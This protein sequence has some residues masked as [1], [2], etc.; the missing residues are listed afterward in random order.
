[1]GNAHSSGKIQQIDVQFSS[2]NQSQTPLLTTT[3]DGRG[4]CQNV[5][6]RMVLIKV[7]SERGRAGPKVILGFCC[8]NAFGSGL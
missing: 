2:V 5:G 8:F 7:D 3:G 4:A 1:M 6:Q